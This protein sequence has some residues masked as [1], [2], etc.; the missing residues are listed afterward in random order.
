MRTYAQRRLSYFEVFC[1][2]MIAAFLMPWPA[3]LWLGGMADIN[4]SYE[5]CF[6]INMAISWFIA[7]PLY[8]TRLHIQGRMPGN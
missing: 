3:M 1:V 5:K 6:G 2:T 8:W 4:W 7:T